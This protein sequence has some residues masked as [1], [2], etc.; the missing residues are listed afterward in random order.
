MRA[1]SAAPMEHPSAQ[2]LPT[3]AGLEVEQNFLAGATLGWR[4]IPSPT[5]LQ[6]RRTR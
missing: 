1:V 4:H 6:Q 3:F 2:G 5:I